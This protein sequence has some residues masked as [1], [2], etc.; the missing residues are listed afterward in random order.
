MLNTLDETGKD[1]FF[2]G[3]KRNMKAKKYRVQ[4]SGISMA[5]N[6]LLNLKF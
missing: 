2:A 4:Y 3:L 5:V 6:Q 1:C